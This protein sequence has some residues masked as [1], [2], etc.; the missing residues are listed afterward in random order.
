MDATLKMPA[1]VRARAV[2][3]KNLI[4]VDPEDPMTRFKINPELDILMRDPKLNAQVRAVQ[5]AMPK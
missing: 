5:R 2:R 1:D 3:I 4:E